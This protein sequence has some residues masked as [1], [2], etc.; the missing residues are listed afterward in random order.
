MNRREL[1]R[2]GLGLALKA[3]VLPYGASDS[4]EP[5]VMT[6]RGP[7]DPAH[8]GKTLPHEHILVDFI[9]AE[10]ATPDRY[11]ADDVARVALPHL[12][13]ARELGCRTLIDC[14]PAYLARD[15]ALLR[16]LSIANPMCEFSGLAKG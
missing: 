8:M 10:R 3:R 12:E 2:S 13:R 6:V 16:R 7:I 4:A 5:R 1:L 11:D 15:A 14:T 9:G